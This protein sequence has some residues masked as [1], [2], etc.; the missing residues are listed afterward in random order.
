[1]SNPESFIEEV[2]EEVRRER[3]FKMFRR[4]GWIG[5]VAVVIL[6]G[7]AAWNEWNKAKTTKAARNLGDSIVAAA[8]S[9]DVAALD[10]VAA[11]GEA[12]ALVDFI[13]ATELLAQE[14][15][16]AAAARLQSVS[17]NTTLPLAFRDLATIKRV[18]IAGDSLDAATRRALLTP[19]A[20]P[21]SPY[22]AVALEQLAMIDVE[23]GNTDAAVEGLNTILSMQEATEGLRQRAAQLIVALGATPLV[24]A[25]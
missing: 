17:D 13:A 16:E 8:A 5:V 11:T 19:A 6:V 15:K 9:E 10:G 20:Q 14:D 23:E 25:N 18:L 21:G 3:L 24:E 1:M 22:R 12:A 2:T 4:Y 7:G